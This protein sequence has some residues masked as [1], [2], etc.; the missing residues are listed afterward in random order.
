LS[1]V[2][3]LSRTEL[4][5]EYDR[6]LTAAEQQLLWDF[7][8]RRE[9]NEPLQYI[10][11]KA[12]F[13]HFELIVNPDVLIPR[14][15][16]ETLVDLVLAVKPQRVLDLGTGSGAIALSLLQE[17]AEVTVWAT[18]LMVKAVI[19]ASEN[20]RLLGFAT[21]TAAA[22]VDV[23]SNGCPEPTDGDQEQI[24]LCRYDF[25]RLHLIESD[26]ACALLD[27]PELHA[28]FDVLVSNPPYIPSS[29]LED[30]PMEVLEYEPLIALDGGE[31]GLEIYRRLLPQAQELLKPG[32]LLAVELY[33]TKLELA[34]QSALKA[35]FHSVQI[36]SDLNGK[37][38]YL[39]AVL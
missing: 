4:Q 17:N 11:G 23:E 7:I 29:L 25:D 36:H 22:D 27:I 6:L 39:T 21:V 9:A 24:S 5:L 37:P 2:T 12:A 1:A 16:T 38:R 3:G 18:D 35:G 31:D 13:R 10:V 19:T 15:E 20:A 32:G 30:L 14:P 34:K 33:E 28:S 26:L 8:C